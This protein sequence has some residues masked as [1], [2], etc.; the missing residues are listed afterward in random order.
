MITGHNNKQ[1]IQHEAK[2]REEAQDEPRTDTECGSTRSGRRHSVDTVSTYLSH[3]SKESLQVMELLIGTV[4][5]VR[6]TVPSDR[7]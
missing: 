4:T 5:F 2:H 6:Q 7:V 1:G 3:E